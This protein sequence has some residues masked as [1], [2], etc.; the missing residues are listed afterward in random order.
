MTTELAR[1][2]CQL[3]LEIRRPVGLLI[4]RRGAVEQVLVGPGCVP[5][6]ESL[7]KFRAGPHSLRGLRLIRIH[8]RDEPLSQEDLTNLALLRLD[9]M[10]ALEV[11]GEGEPRLCHIAHLVPPNAQGR[12]CSVLKPVLFQNLQFPFDTFVSDLEANLQRVDGTHSVTDGQESALLVSASPT[13]VQNRKSIL[14]S[15]RAG[16][17]RG[18]HDRR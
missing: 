5:A 1:T 15:W 12:I 3:T 7:S 2:A 4:T 13:A 18:S 16:C 10:A 14:R 17:L 8:L 11:D 6:F 9:L